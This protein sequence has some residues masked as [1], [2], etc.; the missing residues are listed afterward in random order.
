MDPERLRGRRQVR[1]RARAGHAAR[2]RARRLALQPGD[3]RPP[4]PAAGMWSNAAA[5]CVQRSTATGSPLPLHTSRCASSAR[6]QRQP[7]RR[8]PDRGPASS[9]LRRAGVAG[10]ARAP[11]AARRRRAGVRCS[12]AVPDGAPHAVGDDRDVLDVFY[13]PGRPPG[14]GPDRH[15]RRR[16]PVHRSRAAPGW[17]DLDNGYRRRAATRSQLGPCSQTGVLVAEGR[18]RAD[19][20]AGRAV[21]DR[22]RRGGR[23]APAGSHA[24]TP[25]HADQRGQPSGVA[26]EPG[27]ARWSSSR[28]RLGEPGSVSALGNDQVA[29]RAAGFPTCTACPAD[30]GR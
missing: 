7:R 22:E 2:L 3:Q 1:E 21:R 14:A 26:V 9:L 27:R 18:R 16:Q 6:G 10:R 24:G 5:G 12:C 8:A 25:R 30:P 19:R 29:V 4:V 28:S 17:F 15:R 13:G 11:S 20:A 23:C